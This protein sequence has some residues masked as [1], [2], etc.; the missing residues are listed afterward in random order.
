M[1][2]H[3]LDKVLVKQKTCCC[4]CFKVMDVTDH[5]KSTTSL[6]FKLWMLSIILWGRFRLVQKM[7]Q[8]CT[9][10]AFGPC[11]S[12]EFLV[13]LADYTIRCFDKG[14]KDT[15]SHSVIVVGVLG[16]S[17]DVSSLSLKSAVV[18]LPVSVCQTQSSWSVWC[19]ATREQFRPSP[20]I[21]Q[22]AT[23]SARHW[24]RL[25]SGTCAPF[26]GR[27]SSTSGSLSA[28]RG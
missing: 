11:R 5:K 13:A 23:P 27:G 28:F 20:W 7:G 16:S 19:G 10:L 9:A 12:T 17:Q 26:R 3:L 18:S 25:S 1:I 4:C 8:A 21:A 6:I 22:V 24:T 15:S 2:F 14:R